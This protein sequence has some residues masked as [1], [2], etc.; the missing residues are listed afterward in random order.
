MSHAP[1]KKE[2]HCPSLLLISTSQI[3]GTSGEHGEEAGSLTLRALWETSLTSPRVSL[4]KCKPTDP[5][6]KRANCTC[7]LGLRGRGL[8]G[9][10]WQR[11][12]ERGQL[13]SH[14]GPRPGPEDR[15][16]TLGLR[17]GGLSRSPVGSRTHS[18]LHGH[19]GPAPRR[20]RGQAG[21]AGAPHPRL[22][23]HLSAP[24]HAAHHSLLPGP[25]AG[26]GRLGAQPLGASG[27]GARPA[28]R[29]QGGRTE[30]RVSQPASHKRTT[31]STK[32]QPGDRRGKMR[33]RGPDAN[34]YA[35]VP[36]YR[37]G[38]ELH[39]PEGVGALEQL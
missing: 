9:G 17:D 36:L 18:R 29:P 24:P 19:T 5:L 37:A 15:V 32:K 2:K 25:R 20:G 8:H 14:L 11:T 34:Y 33:L 7:L 27:R 10:P 13:C 35:P 6:T 12:P 22:R 39:F 38:S 16:L 4:L 3:A 21:S 28:D 23:S 31:A 1:I 30:T 26:P